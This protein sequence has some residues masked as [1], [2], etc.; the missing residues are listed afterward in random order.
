LASTSE[1]LYVRL[2]GVFANFALLSLPGSK[3]EGKTMLEVKH[4]A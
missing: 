3:K 2:L 1:Y 4:P